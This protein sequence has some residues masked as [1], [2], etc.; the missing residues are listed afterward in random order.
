MRL[1]RLTTRQ[2]VD[3]LRVASALCPPR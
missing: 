2:H 1:P 3:L